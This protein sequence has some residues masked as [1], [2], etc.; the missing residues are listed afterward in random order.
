MNNSKNILKIENL[1]FSYKNKKILE[2]INLEIN[3]GDFMAL[4]GPN[5]GGK[6]TLIKLILGLLKPDSGTIKLFNDDIK[7]NIKRVS[8]V[9]QI[10]EIKTDFP[11]RAID[12]VLMGR[13]RF[14]GFFKKY[15]KEDYELVQNMLDK[16]GLAN[17][18]YSNISKLSGGQLQRIF[19]ARALVSNA[20][21]LIL[22][23]PTSNVDSQNEKNIIDLLYHLKE[24]KAVLIVTHD[25]G[26]VA[27][28]IN[29]VACLNKNLISHDEPYLTK[30][31][32]E[33]TYHCPIELIGHG[34][35]HRVFKEH[36]LNE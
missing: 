36:D 4:L 31:M 17:F 10:N 26:V 21:F 6:T 16:L 32:I 34:L 19:V 8:F 28:V 20:E 23:E 1:N 33:K 2:N 24:L 27:N 5:G 9:P 11:I 35:P 30:D 13:L 12:V 25:V 14:K 18:A 15:N 7:K 29:K 22:D 3:E